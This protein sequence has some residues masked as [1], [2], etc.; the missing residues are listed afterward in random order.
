MVYLQPYFVSIFTETRSKRSSPAKKEARKSLLREERSLPHK[1]LE[2]LLAA[3]HL[4]RQRF[5]SDKETVDVLLTLAHIV[6]EK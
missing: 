5:Q 4:Y 3:D 1:H 6:R 2:I